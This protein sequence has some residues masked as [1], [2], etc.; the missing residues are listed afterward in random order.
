[1][2]ATAYK[3]TGFERYFY[4][5]MGAVLALGLWMALDAFAG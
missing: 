1:M 3:A 5:W 2:M 4:A